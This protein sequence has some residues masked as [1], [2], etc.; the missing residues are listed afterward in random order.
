VQ[1][2]NIDGELLNIG[3]AGMDAGLYLLRCRFGSGDVSTVKF[4]IIH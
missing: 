4:S 3:T 1:E 2:G